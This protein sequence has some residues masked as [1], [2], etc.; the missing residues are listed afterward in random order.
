MLQRTTAAF[1][2][3]LA[4]FLAAGE[5]ARA[6]YYPPYNQA[7]PPYYRGVPPAPAPW[8]IDDMPVGSVPGDTDRPITPAQPPMPAPG[9]N[10]APNPYGAYRAPA[11]PDSAVQRDPYALPPPGIGPYQPSPGQA[12]APVQP[13]DQAA[14]P[15]TNIRPPA[16]IG[17]GDEQVAALPPDLRPEVGEKELAPNLRRQIIAYQSH[18]PAG[19]IVID[20]PN[21]YLYL[22][23]GNGQ[24]MRYGIGVGR[25]GFTWSGT[26]RIARMAEW[27]DWHPPAEMIERQPYLPRFMAG[28][29]GNPLGARALY[30]G[31]TLYRI[32]GTNQPSTIGTFVSS[33]CIR[34]L[35]ADIEDLYGRVTVGTRVVVLP[36]GKAP[37]TAAAAVP[38]YPQMR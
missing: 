15:P 32:H 27:P 9:A 26:Q 31:N 38:P 19:T 6:Q 17:A 4:V 12:G 23:L 37:D 36:G 29:P 2:G 24:A 33:G 18:E 22:V 20:T 10:A 11:Y 28:G 34:L 8:D 35:N 1:V 13:D 16:T 30:L 7:P 25:E 3:A 5:A 21:T 14:Y